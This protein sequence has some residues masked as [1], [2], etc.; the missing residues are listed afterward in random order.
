MWKP[1]EYTTPDARAKT[2]F[3]YGIF[4]ILLFFT[5]HWLVLSFSPTGDT[6]DVSWMWM[7]GYGL[8]HHLQWGQ[9][10]VNV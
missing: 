3:Y 6:L 1:S 5:M 2:L 7:L 10:Y 8:Q 9:G 4:A